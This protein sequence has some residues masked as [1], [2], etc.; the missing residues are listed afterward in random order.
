MNEVGQTTVI[1]STL[2][3]TI[4]ALI[5]TV[6]MYTQSVVCLAADDVMIETRTDGKTFNVRPY[7]WG[8]PLPAM[9]G[10]MA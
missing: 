2:S 4:V 5:A 9:L 6:L 10:S 8:P 1:N 7:A 3:K